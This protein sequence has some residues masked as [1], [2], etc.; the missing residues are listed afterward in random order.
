M[1]SARQELETARQDVDK[2]KAL[3]ADREE[4]HQKVVKA[5]RSL[6]TKFDSLKEERERVRREMEEA[7]GVCVCVCVHVCVFTDVMVS[8]CHSVQ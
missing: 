7:N 8:S 5:A 6:K 2:F 4:K 1:E 3:A